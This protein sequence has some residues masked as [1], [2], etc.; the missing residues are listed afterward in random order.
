MEKE[1]EWTGF[2][3]MRNA[4]Q[5]THTV[6]LSE[7]KANELW[8]KLREWKG[9]HKEFYF[10]YVNPLFLTKVVGEDYS[11]EV[12]GF[13][14]KCSTK[15]TLME[16]WKACKE[17]FD[18]Y[19]DKSKFIKKAEKNKI[20]FQKAFQNEKYDQ[21]DRHLVPNPFMKKNKKTGV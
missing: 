1:V 10:K 2:S 12:L 16:A 6:K 18:I 13:M 7:E 9:T 3:F 20:E 14:R 15:M 8:K 5:L 11:E 21:K 19:F 17:K 4:I